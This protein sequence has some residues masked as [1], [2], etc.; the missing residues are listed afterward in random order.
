LEE[1]EQPFVARI[2]LVPGVTD[3]HENLSAHRHHAGTDADH[4]GPAAALQPG[5]RGK[6][7]A[8]GMSFQPGFDDIR[9]RTS[10]WNRSV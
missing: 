7:A 6:Y 5:G 9:R 4:R 2:P 3:T 10:M 1:L 8:C